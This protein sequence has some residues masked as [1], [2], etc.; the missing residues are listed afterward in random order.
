MRRKLGK[1]VGSEAAL[2]KVKR[3]I[4][5]KDMGLSQ[6]ETGKLKKK[7]TEKSRSSLKIFK[8]PY[9]EGMS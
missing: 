7:V 4:L 6:G 1:A 3:K 8:S 9:L 2:Q 5:L